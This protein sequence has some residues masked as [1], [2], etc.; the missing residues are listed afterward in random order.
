MSIYVTKLLPMTIL[1]LLVQEPSLLVALVCSLE[2]LIMFK[3]FCY[4]TIRCFYSCATIYIARYRVDC[5][6]QINMLLQSRIK[7][8]RMTICIYNV[9]SID[10]NIK[11]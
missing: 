11:S 9:P 2:S 4:R 5:R 3:P 10:A 7:L 1:L 8:R 6:K